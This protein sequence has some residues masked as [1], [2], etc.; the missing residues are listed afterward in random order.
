MHINQLGA[1]SYRKFSDKSCQPGKL[2][3]PEKKKKNATDVVYEIYSWTHETMQSYQCKM[4][5]MQKDRTFD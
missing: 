4:L 3:K 2:S 1:F 5:K